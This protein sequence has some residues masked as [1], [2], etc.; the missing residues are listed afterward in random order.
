MRLTRVAC[1]VTALLL[2]ASRAEASPGAPDAKES[3]NQLF[4]HG[5]Q[6][7]EQGDYHAALSLFEQS[8][9]LQEAD[10]VL[11]NIA[12]VHKKLGSS[13]DERRAIVR[14]LTRF[15]HKHSLDW[16]LAREHYCW[17]RA[18]EA[19]KTLDGQALK[20]W[21][22]APPPPGQEPPSEDARS[23]SSSS[24]SPPGQEP[25]PTS[26]GTVSIPNGSLPGPSGVAG[27]PVK[28]PAGPP[29][30][31]S[32][33]PKSD[34]RAAGIVMGAVGVA[35][36]VSGLTLG[37]VVWANKPRL[38]DSCATPRCEIAAKQE[39]ETWKRDTSDLTESANAALAVGGVSVG[40]SAFLLLGAF[41]VITLPRVLGASPTRVS[42]APAQ[43]GGLLF[44]LQGSL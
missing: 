35:G 18:K 5:I 2:A 8:Y 42:I 33:P 41:R 27:Q 37:G 32:P 36:I 12:W 29:A 17:L 23:A 43:G 6:A 15:A 44:S 26:R 31:P 20:D 4:D 25:P 22:L 30:P 14:L 16:R 13:N 3:S 28:P 39:Y 19:G 7:A 10:D 34:L 38:P 1:L 40:L 9:E 11:W 24:P 21:C